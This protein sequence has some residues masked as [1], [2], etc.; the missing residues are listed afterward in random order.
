VESKKYEGG[1][2][3]EEGGKEGRRGKGEKGEGGVPFV[4][5]SFSSTCLSA[6]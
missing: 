3:V 1:G 5:I 6:Q 4:N 2:E